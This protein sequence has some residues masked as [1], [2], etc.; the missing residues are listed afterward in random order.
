M[1][2]FFALWGEGVAT[3]ERLRKITQENG[4][5]AYINVLDIRTFYN[6]E[7]QLI[8][9]MIDGT[10]YLV[11]GAP[12]INTFYNAVFQMTPETINV[13]TLPNVTVSSLPVVTLSPVTIQDIVNLNI[14]SVPPLSTAITSVPNL[15]IASIPA[16]SAAITSL[17]N[18]TIASLPNVTIAAL[19][20][21]VIS[22]LPTVNINRA[23]TTSTPNMGQVNVAAS[24]VTILAANANRKQV[25]IR[26]QHLSGDV[27]LFFGA[28]ATLTNGKLLQN[29][30]EYRFPDGFTYTGIITAISANAT[31]KP[32]S[33]MEWV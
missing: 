1:R 3:D 6:M 23:L 15:I 18:I 14:D 22:S 9:E 16:L 21:I 11:Q 19:P 13:A 7:G 31:S 2:L 25:E 12:D 29:G 33:Y 4:R 28:T 30:E 27:Y 17:P 8:I 24:S 5:D 32:V 10:R 26:N 20:N